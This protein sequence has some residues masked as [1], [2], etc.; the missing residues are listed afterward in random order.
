MKQLIFYLE[1]ERTLPGIIRAATQE[2]AAFSAAPRTTLITVFSANWNEPSL[3]RTFTEV[4]SAFPD[5][6]L[7]G[8]RVPRVIYNGRLSPVGTVISFTFFTSAQLR[9]SLFDAAEE[10]PGAFAHALSRQLYE[11]PDARA[12]FLLAAGSGY[13]L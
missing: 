12:L 13:N 3:E 10:R 9:L 2:L 11:T 1:N 5:A 7:L 6:I 4:N 8:S